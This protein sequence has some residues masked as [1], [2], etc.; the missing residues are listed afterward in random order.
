MP[1]NQERHGKRLFVREVLVEQDSTMRRTQPNKL[2]MVIISDMGTIR[3]WAYM[4]EVH[5]C[6]GRK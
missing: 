1:A 6:A 5:S 2:I 3:N 4:V